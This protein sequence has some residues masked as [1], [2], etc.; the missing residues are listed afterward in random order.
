MLHSCLGHTAER[1]RAAKRQW[2]SFNYVLR[3]LYIHDFLRILGVPV[4]VDG[5][6]Y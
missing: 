1:P 3:K 5:D 4:P 6:E 2:E